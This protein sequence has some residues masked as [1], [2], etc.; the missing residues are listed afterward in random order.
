MHATVGNRGLLELVSGEAMEEAAATQ[1]ASVHGLSMTGTEPA[2]AE[3]WDGAMASSIVPRTDRQAGGPYQRVTAAHQQRLSGGLSLTLS[4]GLALEL[5][6]FKKIWQQNRQRYEDVAAET[7]IPALLIAAIHYRESSGDFSRYLHQ[8]DPLGRPAVRVP[9]NIP[10]FH[11]WHD[12]AVH[13]LNMKR[14][15][16]DRV[17]L[18]ANTKDPAAIATFAEAY[19]GL[20]YHN[21]GRVSPYVYS[22]TDA[23]TGGKYVRDSVFS[24]STIDQQIGVLAMMDA[25]GGLEGIDM[26]PLTPERA[27]ARVAA[28]SLLLRQGSTHM[29]VTHLQQL[30]K[31]SGQDIGVDGRFGP[32]TRGAVAR[33][34]Q[35]EGLTADGIVGRATAAA[36]QRR[37]AP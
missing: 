19:N 7:G 31:A 4:S 29:A 36:L 3:R 34:Q 8:G 18:D 22:G 33:F 26:A 11:H 23:Y 5:E 16:R 15:I 10:V 37:A 6:T 32:G 9:N 2:A 12:A 27:W 13:A 14:T 1:I 28:G 24:A 20:G 35:G 30:L 17:G 25:A 21:A